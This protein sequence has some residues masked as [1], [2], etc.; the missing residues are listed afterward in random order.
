MALVWDPESR[1]D[2]IRRG[3]LNV[4]HA[5]D[6]VAG[7]RRRGTLTVEQLDELDAAVDG[8][9]RTWREQLWQAEPGGHTG[10]E[11]DHEGD[12]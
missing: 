6:L 5:A 9:R 3:E 12:G 1:A 8:L 2:Q 4:I 10:D 7:Q 11:G